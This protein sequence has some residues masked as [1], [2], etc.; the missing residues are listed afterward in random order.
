VWRWAAEVEFEKQVEDYNVPIEPTDHYFITLQ[1]TNG[2]FSLLI[3][4][5]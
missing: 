1:F 4:K 5:L 3:G 2:E